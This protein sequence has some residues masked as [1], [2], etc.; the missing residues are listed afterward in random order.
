[1]SFRDASFMGIMRW[2]FYNKLKEEYSDV[3]M[4]YGYITK[5]IRIE[6][7]LPKEHFVD[8]RCISGNPTAISYNV[9]Y[10]Q[11]KVRCH[12]RQI[13]KNTILKG[14]I[15]KR[16]QAEYLVK[17]FRL[18]DKVKVKNKN[19]YI[20]GRRNKGSFVLKDFQNNT[21]EIT[22]TKIKFLE[23]QN[24]FITERRILGTV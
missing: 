3:H 22:P 11:K 10:Y 14:G 15:R 21:L 9:V 12:N 8:A 1:M 20:H 24:S 5:N 13:H 17:G 18:F 7:N 16:N 4:T 23:Y 19:W 6:N 2:A